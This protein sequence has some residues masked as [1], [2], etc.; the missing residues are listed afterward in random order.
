MTENNENNDA[1]FVMFGDE[2]CTDLDEAIE[3]FCK[4]YDGDTFYEIFD[5][6]SNPKNQNEYENHIKKVL[7]EKYDKLPFYKAVKCSKTFLP[8]I[9]ILEII[10]NEFEHVDYEYEFEFEQLFEKNEYQII[11]NAEKQINDILGKFQRYQAG[12][13]IPV[14]EIIQ[15]FIDTISYNN[16]L[17]YFNI[18]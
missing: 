8:K 9:N 1:D 13:Q 3:K 14:E 4:D 5:N 11:I 16:F 7:Q 15:C 12:D 18:L 17:D 10:E 2:L 6:Y